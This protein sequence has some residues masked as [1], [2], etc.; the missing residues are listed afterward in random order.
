MLYHCYTDE[1]S[2]FIN[3]PNHE[4]LFWAIDEYIDPYAVKIQTMKSNYLSICLKKNEYFE[5]VDDSDEQFKGY[6]W[7]DPQ[8]GEK[9][10]WGIDDERPVY[11]FNDNKKLER[12]K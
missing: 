12:V 7:S 10:Y 11:R 9:M 6:D 8:L 1:Y 3:A 2:M 5:T 4:F